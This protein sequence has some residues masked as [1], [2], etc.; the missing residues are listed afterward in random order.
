MVKHKIVC[1]SLTLRDRAIL[2]KFL[3]HRV[4]LRN[5]PRN[6]EK[7]SSFQKWRN[8]LI[9]DKNGKTLSAFI[10]L[11]VRDRTIRAILIEYFLQRFFAD[12]LISEKCSYTEN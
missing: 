2:L 4:H 8:F 9:F 3:T 10:S 6:F 11:I 1:I 12:A 5:T 7:F